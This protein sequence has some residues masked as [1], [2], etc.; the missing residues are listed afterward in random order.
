MAGDTIAEKTR[1]IAEYTEQ[2]EQMS[3]KSISED[4]AEAAQHVESNEAEMDKARK[5]REAEHADFLKNEQDL[6]ESVDALDR[7]IK[8]LNAEPKKVAQ[9]SLLE[10]SNK[11]M[12]P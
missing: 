6:M 5:Q 12:I 2:M 11:K 8:T 9:A 7:A 10:L 1:L 3:A 4:A